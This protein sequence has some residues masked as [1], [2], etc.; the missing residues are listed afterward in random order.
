M[1]KEVEAELVAVVPALRIAREVVKAPAALD[2]L[3]ALESDAKR[4]QAQAEAEGDQRCA[5]MAVGQ[6]V[7]IIEAMARLTGEDLGNRAREIEEPSVELPPIDVHELAR[8]A[9]LTSPQTDDELRLVLVPRDAA[10]PEGTLDAVTRQPIG[11]VPR[12]AILGRDQN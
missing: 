6:L 1:T 10:L 2:R 4:I 5:L 7:R 9:F 8:L 12:P 11:K 3:R